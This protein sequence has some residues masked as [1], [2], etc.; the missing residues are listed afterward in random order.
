M[1]FTILDAAF[2]HLD[3]NRVKSGCLR[4]V[5][6][7][8][9]YFHSGERRLF[10]GPAC[11]VQMCRQLCISFSTVAPL[12]Q[13]FSFHS[14]TESTFPANIFQRIITAPSPSVLYFCRFNASQMQLLQ[15][16][17]LLKVDNT[18]SVLQ[19]TPL[20]CHA[21]DLGLWLAFHQS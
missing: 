15:P 12:Y 20:P 18:S 6:F 5:C 3:K 19:T 9:I 21:L 4:S 10:S 13:H 17:S 14:E 7:R 16:E 1:I 2:Y 8:L 11:S